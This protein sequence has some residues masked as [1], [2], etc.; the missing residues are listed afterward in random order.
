MVKAGPIKAWNLVRHKQQ[1]KSICKYKN[2]EFKCQC[3]DQFL[4]IHENQH[5]WKQQKP[6]YLSCNINISGQSWPFLYICLII[7]DKILKSLKQKV[8]SLT[9]ALFSI[10]LYKVVSP[11]HKW[12]VQDSSRRVTGISDICVASQ[13][14][15]N[16]ICSITDT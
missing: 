16:A 6:Q 1:E 8:M 13:Q 12:W 14:S 3:T 4:S 9:S 5:Q 10:F 15:I 7:R 11:K 2:Y